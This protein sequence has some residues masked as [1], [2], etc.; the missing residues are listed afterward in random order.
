MTMRIDS[1]D[2]LFSRKELH[3]VEREKFEARVGVWYGFIF[4]VALVAVG[5]G[6]DA[7]ELGRAASEWFWL[8][9]L[10]NAIALIPLCALAG[11]VAG[12]IHNSLLRRVLVW[13][14]L[15]ATFG[16]L[17]LYLSFAGVSA[18]VALLDSSVHGITLYPFAPA[19]QERL[20]L[21]A[22]FGMAAGIL[23]AAAQNFTT[24][25]AWDNSSLDDRLT[26]QGWLMLWA[27]APLAIGLGALYDGSV[28]SQMRAPV[29]LTHR[30]VQLMLAT[31]PDADFRKMDTFTMLDY[32]GTSSWQK[33]FSPRYLQRIA[34]LD[35]KTL[36]WAFV[37]TEF[38]NGFI[39]RCQSVRN[40]DG[41]RDCVDLQAQSRDWMQQFIR[42]GIVQCADC[43]VTI[44]PAAQI[45][46][47]QN[48]SALSAPQQITLTHHSGGL[49][50]MTATLSTG[51]IE[52]R[53]VGANP[54]II[55]DCARKP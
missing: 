49:I 16:P 15:G 12:R 10:L 34:D 37:D 35:R 50:V 25:W 20:P 22:V 41:V 1:L 5:W 39:W 6:W 55:N 32:V 44:S 21:I 45:W 18:I 17:S 40:G 38:D 42:T 9:L 53:F 28:N 14:A 3:Q 31:P 33:N 52:C 13:V 24:A 23:T 43:A 48:A 4:G 51:Q 19:L 26:T 54:T 47:A 11:L 36:T 30:L 46:H 2:K 8:K 7:Y 27:C 29:Q